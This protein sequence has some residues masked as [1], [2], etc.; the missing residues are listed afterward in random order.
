MLLRE[1]RKRLRQELALN[2]YQQRRREFN[3]QRLHK[4]PA[5]LSTTRRQKL[6]RRN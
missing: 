5:A 6:N 4:H 3:A 1:V 2:A